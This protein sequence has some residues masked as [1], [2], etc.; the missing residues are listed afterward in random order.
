MRGNSETVAW[1]RLENG[2]AAEVLASGLIRYTGPDGR[3]TTWRAGRLGKAAVTLLR[4]GIP[5]PPRA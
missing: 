5:R 4:A 3:A 2:G 1:V